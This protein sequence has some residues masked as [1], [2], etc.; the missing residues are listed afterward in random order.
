LIRTERRR[1]VRRSIP[2]WSHLSQTRQ[3][4]K[5]SVRYARHL[6]GI[7]CSW[8]GARSIRAR[9]NSTGRVLRRLSAGLRSSAPLSVCSASQPS[10]QPLRRYRP[11]RL[12]RCRRWIWAANQRRRH[13]RPKPE[14]RLGERRSQRQH[15][16]EQPFQ[17]RERLPRRR[18][19]CV[20]S[21]A[22]VQG[23]D[24]VPQAWHR[25]P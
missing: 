24:A 21:C 3:R 6:A 10:C 14:C 19:E 16:P 13:C 1:M 25:Q 5:S 20:A 7:S 12:H 8:C 23:A 15:Q 17:S 4:M 22:G 18:K 11:V 2:R 9:R